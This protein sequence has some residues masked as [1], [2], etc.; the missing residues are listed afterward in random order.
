M[1]I[2]ED[3]RDKLKDIEE[4][5]LK[6]YKDNKAEKKRDWRTYEQ[7]LANRIKGAIHN[8]EL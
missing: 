7:Q 4:F 1:M 6:K 8:L 3:I 2:S 5:L